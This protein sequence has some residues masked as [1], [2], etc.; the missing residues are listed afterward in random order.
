MN[1]IKKLW[2]FLKLLYLY[3]AYWL[4]GITEEEYYILKGNYCVDLRWNRMAIR[5]YEKARKESKDPR[6]LSMLGL[7]YLRVGNYDKSVENYRIA[8]EKFKRPKVAVGLAITEYETGNINR[9]A[10][11]IEILNTENDLDVADKAALIKL[12]GLIANKHDE[13]KTA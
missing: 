3:T 7:C 9:S 1:R 6:I 11:I 12:K 13:S 5:S 4:A 8:Y 10:E 2:A